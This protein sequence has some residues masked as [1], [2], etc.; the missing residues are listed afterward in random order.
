MTSTVLT[1]GKTNLK[2][3]EVIHQG[4]FHPATCK[5]LHLPSNSKIPSFETFDLLSSFVVFLLVISSRKSL[6]FRLEFSCA[7]VRCLAPPDEEEDSIFTIK[8]N[9]IDVLSA[10]V[11][12]ALRVFEF[13]SKYF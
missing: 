13:S 5:N 9:G 4:E 2:C 12:G 10:K 8:D 6:I 1:A 7:N 11:L 3:S